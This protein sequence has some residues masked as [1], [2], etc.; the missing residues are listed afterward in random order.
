MVRTSKDFFGFAALI[1]LLIGACIGAARL[2]PPLLGAEAHD[3]VVLTISFAVAKG[4]LRVD[5]KTNGRQAY[6]REAE[7]ASCNRFLC[8]VV[9]EVTVK[10]SYSDSRANLAL[11]LRASISLFPQLG[12]PRQG[13][14]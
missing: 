1:A 14:H 10:A 4:E 5:S 11:R 9:R 13:W 2:L 8:A 6:L 7:A 12:R 3:C